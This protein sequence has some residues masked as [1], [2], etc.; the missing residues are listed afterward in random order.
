MPRKKHAALGEEEGPINEEQ[1]L[2]MDKIKELNI[3]IQK[4]HDERKATSPMRRF[5]GGPS[6]HNRS[7]ISKKSIASKPTKRVFYH[8]NIDYVYAEVT[9]S[10]YLTKPDQ[11]YTKETLFT[12]N[13][14]R[15]LKVANQG[16]PLR[17]I[18]D[19]PCNVEQAEED[20]LHKVIEYKPLFDVHKDANN[21]RPDVHAPPRPGYI[22]YPNKYKP[23][24]GHTG[25]LTNVQPYLLFDPEVIYEP[26]PGSNG[27][28][29]LKDYKRYLKQLNG[30]LEGP[31]QVFTAMKQMVTSKNLLG[32]PSRDDNSCI[33]DSINMSSYNQDQ[34]EDFNLVL[35]HS[36]ETSRPS[37]AKLEPLDAPPSPDMRPSTTGN[38]ERESSSRLLR[39]GSSS[40]LLREGSS[41]RL[42]R[43][44]STSSVT[45]QPTIKRTNSGTYQAHTARA[46]PEYFLSQKAVQKSY[47]QFI[48][49][50]SKDGIDGEEE[51]MATIT[52]S[53]SSGNNEVFGEDDEEKE[54]KNVKSPKKKKIITKSNSTGA[55]SKSSSK[56]KHHSS[57][58]SL[59]SIDERDVKEISDA[60][61]SRDK[62]SISR[63]SSKEVKGEEKRLLK[64]KS[65]SRNLERTNS[66][67]DSKSGSAE[68]G[69]RQSKKEEEMKDE[70]KPKRQDSESKL[71]S[72]P[73][74]DE[75]AD[76]SIYQDD[77]DFE[78][79]TS[80]KIA[81]I[82]NENDNHAL[83]QHG[84]LSPL[85]YGETEDD[86][87]TPMSRSGSMAGKRK[88]GSDEA[89]Q[90]LD[91]ES[92][93]LDSHNPDF[94][95]EQDS[96]AEDDFEPMSANNSPEKMYKGDSNVEEENN[97]ADVY[98]LSDDD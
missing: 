94:D 84:P 75:D 60:K 73:S 2:A 98:D 97:D 44:D 74:K 28:L 3:Q 50:F 69:R 64:G 71:S 23:L 13:K 45:S 19:T 96:Y 51:F 72:T 76:L 15:K 92:K 6:G 87:H 26:P 17:D 63:S 7:K 32:S 41:S 89:P 46:G 8:P 22:V 83:H 55:E 70:P 20:F 39:E 61:P 82:D 62:N 54:E 85:S 9:N 4:I 43:E 58:T 38:L 36:P 49:S 86:T 66:K 78:S 81:D 35:T 79:C 24:V 67:A 53:N 30:K 57:S 34:D 93:I 11:N 42:Q 90:G 77:D 68:S 40:R 1:K 16:R 95:K 21:Y 88:S 31:K 5:N 56:L 33:G 48:L 18:Q 12:S 52:R 80:Q 10:P 27:I 29:T 65:S 25:K 14:L 47:K 59:G 91:T 37:S